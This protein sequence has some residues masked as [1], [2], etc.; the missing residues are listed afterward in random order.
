MIDATVRIVNLKKKVFL[1]EAPEGSRAE[2]PN[3]PYVTVQKSQ[4]RVLQTNQGHLESTWRGAW[5]AAPRVGAAWI[6]FFCDG[7]REPPEGPWSGAHC[8][9]VYYSKLSLG[10]YAAGYFRETVA[11]CC[12]GT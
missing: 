6:S 5:R 4:R 1:S 3:D 12:E 7:S 9:T 10:T 11:K 2:K 8:N